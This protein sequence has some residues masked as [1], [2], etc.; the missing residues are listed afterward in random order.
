[1]SSMIPANQITARGRLCLL[2]SKKIINLSTSL[3]VKRS[4]PWESLLVT[5]NRPRLYRSLENSFIHE[6]GTINGTDADRHF[7]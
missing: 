2:L 7:F 1:M 3:K 5:Y 6:N 4:R